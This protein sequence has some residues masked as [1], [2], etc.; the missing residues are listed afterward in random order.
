VCRAQ[1]RHPSVVRIDREVYHPLCPEAEGV[2]GLVAARTL[3]VTVG[4]V[5]RV[6]ALEAGRR[7][8]TLDS[9]GV[10]R[11]PRLA[12]VVRDIHRSAVMA[13][14]AERGRRSVAL[15]AD[16]RILLAYSAVGLGEGRRM[17]HGNAVAVRTE[18]A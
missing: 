7:S 12:C 11:A 17:R 1:R 9:R 2:T 14:V 4:A 18:R 6:V 16:G 3:D 15:D 10:R 13:L 8:N 5:R